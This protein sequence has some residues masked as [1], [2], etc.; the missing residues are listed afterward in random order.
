MKGMAFVFKNAD[1]ARLEYTRVN[2]LVQA[3]DTI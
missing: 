1:A 2:E 3:P